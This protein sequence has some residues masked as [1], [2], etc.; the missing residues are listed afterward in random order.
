M[1]TMRT[2]LLATFAL[3]AG[4]AHSGEVQYIAAK[5]CTVITQDGTTYV[6]YSSQFHDA[7]SIPASLVVHVDADTI[8]F[9]GVTYEL[10]SDTITAKCG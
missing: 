7:E 10:P 4:V 3:V 1:G 8:E 6:L 5:D 9:R 2:I